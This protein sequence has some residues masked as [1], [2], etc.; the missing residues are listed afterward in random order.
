MEDEL[1][2]SEAR[3]RGVV[4]A[5]Q[6]GICFID[7]VG[8]ILYRSPSCELV[9]GYSAEERIGL[10]VHEIVHPADSNE[11]LGALALRA[12]REQPDRPVQYRIQRKDGGW[13]W[14]ETAA[15]SLLDN[16]SV[17]AIV[18]ATTD[19]TDRRRADEERQRLG[20]QLAHA[21]K[22]ESVGRLAGGIAHDF[23]NLMSV[24]LLHADSALDELAAGDPP[25]DSV[26]A[27][28]DAADRAIS[29]GRQLMTLSS[30]QVLQTEI[31]ELNSVVEDSRKLVSRLI[32]EDVQV[33][34]NPDC[35]PAFVRADRGQ[36]GPVILNLAVNSRDA[37]PEGG[38]FTIETTVVEFDEAEA[39]MNPESKPGRYVR[40]AVCDTGIGMNNETRRRIFEPF[41]ST[42]DMS[43]GTGLGL[44]VVYGIVKQ[45]DGFI[46]VHSEP[47]RGAEFRIYLPALL[48]APLP[49]P[50][51]AQ[52]ASRGGSETILLVEDEPTLREKL[53]AVLKDAGYRLL[54]AANGRE[55]IEFAA[56]EPG[57]IHLLFSDVVMPGMSGPQ[58]ARSMRTSRPD[59]GVVLMSG[60][61]GTRD[62]GVDPQFQRNFLQKPFT[63][64]ELLRRV[65]DVL[66]RAE[67]PDNL[68]QSKQ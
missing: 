58:L 50:E 61:P 64:E 6:E 3:F 1:R 19:I 66:D 22:M 23:N 42:K 21:Q 33:V 62:G 5:S 39:R 54:V 48:E 65:R 47:G 53:Q 7:T 60:Y 29:L 41:F 31:L 32:G 9:D 52:P 51:R 67:K 25:K 44:S 46:T 40:M 36:L 43:T 16:P 49:A 13:R 26:I 10:C 20:Q 68:P 35:G 17:H 30:K 56:R 27:I 38:T 24:V 37:M 55:A 34:F 11:V 2:E 59:T 57:P 63:T 18:L 15:R 28:R 45:S 4:E 14:V 12:D 8:T